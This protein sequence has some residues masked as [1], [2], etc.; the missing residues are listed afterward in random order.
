MDEN[1]K[2]NSLNGWSDGESNGWLKNNSP[3]RWSDRRHEFKAVYE[4]KLDFLIFLFTVLIYVLI[5][6][7]VNRKGNVVLFV[8][9]DYPY[10]F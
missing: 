4:S 6:C 9:C 7:D 5:D 10:V 1:N 2:N 8:L 3:N